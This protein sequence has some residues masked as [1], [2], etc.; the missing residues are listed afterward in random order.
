MSPHGLEWTIH[1]TQ[2]ERSARL[3]YA[4]QGALQVGMGKCDAAVCCCDAL[5]FNWPC[6]RAAKPPADT[7]KQP[8]KNSAILWL[9]SGLELKPTRTSGWHGPDQAETIDNG[10]NNNNENHC[11]Y[12][13]LY[14]KHQRGIHT[15]STLS[16]SRFVHTQLTRL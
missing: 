3:L 8:L 9:I 6:G 1:T 11:H 15:Y 7:L 12:L 13:H 5:F 16:P 2:I 10:N 14:V 4:A